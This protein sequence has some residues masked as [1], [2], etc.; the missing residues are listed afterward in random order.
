MWLDPQNPRLR[1]LWIRCLIVAVPLIG[2]A[3]SFDQ[4]SVPFGVI[5]GLAGGFAFRRLFL[6]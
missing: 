4:G 1:P 3:A 2:S 5:F 6:P